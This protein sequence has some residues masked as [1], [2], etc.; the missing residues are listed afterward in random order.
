MCPK[1]TVLCIQKSATFRS[2]SSSPG[3]RRK[4]SPGRRRSRSKS[5]SRKQ[6]SSP[7]KPSPAR[8]RGRPRN[9]AS[10][11]SAAVA[12]EEKPPAEQGTVTVTTKTKVSKTP[13]RTAVGQQLE[14]RVTRSAL[15]ILEK[16]GIDTQGIRE[17]LGKGLYDREPSKPQSSAFGGPIGALF[18]MLSLPFLVFATYLYC[19]KEK[20]YRLGDFFKSP[21]TKL[22]P[23]KEFFD[24][25]AAAMV[26]GWMAFQAFLNLLPL[27]KVSKN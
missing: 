8:G 25:E 27:G 19:N 9:V 16:Q 26:Y 11:Q 3:R 18:L 24:P 10:Q 15:K 17:G 1:T 12:K 4:S 23:A 21:K 20:C 14:A 7:R 13:P 2:R 22:P 6:S 5:P